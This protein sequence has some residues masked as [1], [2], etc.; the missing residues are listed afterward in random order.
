MSSY[1]IISIPG[2]GIGKEV[3]PESCKVLDAV[4]DVCGFSLDYT[5]YGAF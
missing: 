3:I 5:N 4:A 2:D 1:K